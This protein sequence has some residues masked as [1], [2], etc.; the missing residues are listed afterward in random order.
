MLKEKAIYDKM[1][2]FTINND[3][4]YGKVWVPTF[5]A[6]SIRKDIS[7]IVM[8]NVPQ[9][10]FQEICEHEL[11]PPTY[12]RG[13]EFLNPPQMIVDTYGV[14]RYKEVNPALFTAVTFPFLFGVMFGDMSLGLLLFIMGLS[15]IFFREQMGNSPLAALSEF[16]YLLALMG[17]FAFYCGFIYN[18]FICMSLNL[19]GSCYEVPPYPE[20][21]GLE[22][23]PAEGCVYPAGLDPVWSRSSNQLNYINSLKMKLSVIIGVAHMV[24]GIFMKGANSIRFRK[25][26]DFFFEFLPQIVFMTAMFVYMDFLIVFKWCKAWTEE[27]IPF[28]PSIITTMIN[29]PLK[30]GH[31]TEGGGGEPLWGN[32][33]DTSQNTVQ[34]VLLLVAAT[35]VPLMLLPKPLILKF[36]GRPAGRDSEVASQADIKPLL[37]EQDPEEQ[38]L[39]A[40]PKHEEHDEVFVHQVIETIEFVLGS[41]SNTASYLR[42][43]AL[44]LA[45]EQLSEV[46]FEK[47]IQDSIGHGYSGI[48]G[49]PS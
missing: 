47:T 2:E 13:N 38:S 27:T 18:D 19:F 40:H 24:L 25:W 29:I 14:P 34:L 32:Y 7:S 33:E 48:V 42:L 11:T 3:F 10:V 49:V 12:F 8:D 41:V 22:L 28:A 43:W 21:E 37:I 15:L 46:F 39:E 36:R 23:R 20:G 5:R 1:N 9:A 44:S 35:C 31:T 6:A 4:I 16:R 26:L 30:L 45:H 17:F